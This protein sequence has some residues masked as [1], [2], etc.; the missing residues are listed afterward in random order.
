MGGWLL[1][2]WSLWGALWY[3]CESEY[4]GYSTCE[5][6]CAGSGVKCVANGCSGYTALLSWV[7]GDFDYCDVP[8]YATMDGPCDEPIPWEGESWEGMRAM[9]CCG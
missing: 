1:P 4:N 3:D 2:R 8:P 6:I 5:E 9:C 7:G